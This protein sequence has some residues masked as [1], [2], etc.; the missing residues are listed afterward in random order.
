[1]RLLPREPNTRQS[2]AG[3]DTRMTTDEAPAN[4]VGALGDA[5]PIA[6][7]GIN[8]D[9][10]FA[11]RA[12]GEV[13]GQLAYILSQLSQQDYANVPSGARLQ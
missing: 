6:I 13:R 4:L 5:M 12:L 9:G 1:M 10:T 11:L 8:E 3:A 7:I 2:S